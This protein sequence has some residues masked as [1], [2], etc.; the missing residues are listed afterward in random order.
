M[1]YQLSNTGLENKGIS[2]TTNSSHLAEWGIWFSFNI[3]L[4]SEAGAMATAEENVYLF[5]G[6]S[7]L[8]VYCG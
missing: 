4:T 1:I 5:S 8:D 3:L 2:F 7:V 6:P